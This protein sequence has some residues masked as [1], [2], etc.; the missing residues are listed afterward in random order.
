MRRKK[1]TLAAAVSL[2]LCLATTA[3]WA[4]TTK[5]TRTIWRWGNEPQPR[6]ARVG[7][8]V[9]VI[10]HY[11]PPIPFSDT[12]NDLVPSLI[13]Q[14]WIIEGSIRLSSLAAF[15]LLLPTIWLSAFAYSRLQR[16][17]RLLHQLCASCG[18]D[19]TGNTSGICPECGTPVGGEAEVKA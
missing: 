9:I 6:A 18:Y 2:L 7:R 1:F 19:L 12:G 8:G 11:P 5:Q 13:S 15:F 4:G 17:H 10:E 14:P 16:R 3:L